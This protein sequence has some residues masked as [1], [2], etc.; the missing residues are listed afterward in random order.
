MIRISVRDR[1]IHYTCGDVRGVIYLEKAPPNIG[2]ENVHLY[3]D[4]SVDVEDFKKR[5]SNQLFEVGFSRDLADIV[6]QDY[7]QGIWDGTA[8]PQP[9]SEDRIQTLRAKYEGE[10]VEKESIEE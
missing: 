1:Q 5:V 9:T 8:T 10:E 2:P 6:A 4:C 7:C 3:P